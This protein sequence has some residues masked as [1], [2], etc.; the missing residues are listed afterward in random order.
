MNWKKKLTTCTALIVFATFIAHIINK[1]IY[2]MAT[3]DSLLSKRDGNYYEWRFGK[4]FYTKQGSG[5][6][7]LLIHD[8]NVCSSEY[9]WKKIISELSKTNTVYALDLLGC[10]KSEKPNIT[11]TNYLYV[12][13]VTDFVKQIIGEKT[14]VIATGN[15]GSFVLMA[16]KNDKTIINKIMLINPTSI[17]SLAQNA[18]KKT[19]ILK[20]LIT[21]PVVGTLLY[22]IL[23]SKESIEQTCMAEYFYNP[24]SLDEELIKVYHESSHNEN[25]SSKFLFA[26]I[27]G[28]YTNVNII[29]CLKHL[30]N[31]IFIITGEGNPDYQ[32]IAEHYQSYTP[33]IEIQKIAKTKFLPQLE[34][35]KKVLEQIKLL[36][37]LDEN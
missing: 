31:S 29:E 21:M 32:K 9:E 18:T 33:S 22:N 20:L 4:I 8:L 2:L 3:V 35:P 36:F 13:L 11:Y 10:G 14:D 25:S 7:I 12:Q 28:R 6:P 34:A 17:S 1:F 30:D 23:H 27:K 16:C 5:T 26:S 37:E 24:H 15:S 19:K